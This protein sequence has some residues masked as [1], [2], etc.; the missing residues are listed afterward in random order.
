[1]P[2]NLAK[3]AR[4]QEKK[5]K[6]NLRVVSSAVEDEEALF[7]R[8]I[9]AEGNGWFKIAVAD[10]KD[11]KR[12]IEV[13][14]RVGGRSVAR[15]CTNDIVIVAQSGKVYEL[16]GSVNA[17]T[18]KKLQKDKRIHPGLLSDAGMNEEELGIVFEAEEE[19]KKE[20]VVEEV[21]EKAA[22]KKESV[23]L[24][25]ELEDLDIDDI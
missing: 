14:A 1:M 2:K 21:K 11:R 13:H 4:V 6:R 25:E 22:P 12:L 23:N 17:D 8:T 9:K 19:E 24:K 18:A 10:P 15:I 16:M 7:G 3:A 5:A 20:V